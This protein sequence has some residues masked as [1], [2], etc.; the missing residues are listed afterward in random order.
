[1]AKPTE[2]FGCDCCGAMVPQSQIRIVIVHGI[3][4]SACKTCRHDDEPEDDSAPKDDH[5]LI[6]AIQELL[7]GTEWHSGMLEQIGEW[8]QASGYRVRDID[9]MDTPLG[10]TI[11]PA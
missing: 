11:W 5:D 9:D 10:T 3:E 1:M 8:L 6:L 4:T 7:D 2:E